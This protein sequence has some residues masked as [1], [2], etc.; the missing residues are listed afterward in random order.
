MQ[1]SGNLILTGNTRG[2]VYFWSQDSGQLETVIQAH[3]K[4]I[5]SLAIYHGHF[6]TSSR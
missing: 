3:D 4:P 1:W 6:Y 5:L 2:H